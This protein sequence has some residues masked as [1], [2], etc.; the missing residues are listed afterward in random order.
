MA[1]FL[2]SRPATEWWLVVATRT[3]EVQLLP[4]LAELNERIWLEL[5]EEKGT[6][7]VPFGW[8]R[9]WPPRPLGLSAGC[10]RAPQVA[11][12]SVEVLMSSRSLPEAVSNSV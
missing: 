9:G 6:I 4:P 12:P 7:T 10:F 3:L 8:T 5:A 2:A 11:P 1:A